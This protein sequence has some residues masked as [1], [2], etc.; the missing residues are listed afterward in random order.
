MYGNT[1]PIGCGSGP[2]GCNCWWYGGWR[3]VDGLVVAKSFVDG[4]DFSHGW[5][6]LLSGMSGFEEFVVWV[7]PGVD[8][9]VPG[10]GLFL[11]VV[12]ESG[13]CDKVDTQY[14]WFG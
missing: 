4:H 6:L 5:L 10:K 8:D 11:W 7:V 9:A 14:S 2:A 1:D 3:L 12:S 13:F